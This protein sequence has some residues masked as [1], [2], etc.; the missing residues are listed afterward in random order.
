MF[1]RLGGIS[2]FQCL[3]WIDRNDMDTFG[4]PTVRGLGHYEPVLG[5]CPTVTRSRNPIHAGS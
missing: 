5:C 4:T 1:V 3:D 2:P